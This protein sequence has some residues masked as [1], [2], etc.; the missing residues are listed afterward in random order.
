MNAQ[1]ESYR[2]QIEAVMD[3]VCTVARGLNETQFNWRPRP[4]SWS[5]G[6]CVDHLNASE[7]LWLDGIDESLSAAREKQLFAEGPF[8]YGS[9]EKWF[10][11][12]AEPPVRFKAKAPKNF[13]PQANLSIER[14]LADFIDLHN[15][16]QQRIWQAQGIDL[17]RAKV[18]AP[19]AKWL[20]FSLGI[21]FAIVAAHDRR[22]LWQAQQ[23]LEDPA[24][25]K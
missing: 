13:Q 18:R 10:L 22:H 4:G 15:R 16:L 11:G 1:L 24:F 25:P 9:I 14:T 17:R 7:R 6:E 8:R 21:S 12:N 3:D 5:V 19:F 23:V 2:G 20:K